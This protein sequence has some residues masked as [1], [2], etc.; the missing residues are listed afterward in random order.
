M[1]NLPVKKFTRRQPGKS[2]PAVGK[3]VSR[4]SSPGEQTGKLPLLAPSNPR[5]TKTPVP[6]DKIILTTGIILFVVTSSAVVSTLI[7]KGSTETGKTPA[8]QIENSQP[9]RTLQIPP[10]L[11]PERIEIIAQL[12]THTVNIE[13]GTFNPLSLTIKLHDQVE[14]HNN[15]GE[16][17]KVKG[18]DWGNVPIDPG[19]IFS[20][21]FETAG[22]FTYSCAL[23]PGVTGTVIVE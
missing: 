8:A 7:K 18:K 11:T 22:T 9:D 14:W 19:M 20:Q 6:L 4:S 1:P 15:T 16:T 21:A 17:Y 5:P 12:E 2:S 13:N 10:T 23:H 3:L